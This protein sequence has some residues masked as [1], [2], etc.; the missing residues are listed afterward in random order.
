MHPIAE[1][2]IRKSALP[3]I[4]CPGC[5]HGTVLNAFLHAVD[6]LD[7]FSR[8]ALVS[9]IGCSSWTPVFVNTDVMHTLHGRALAFATGLKIANPKLCVAVFTGDGDGAGIGGNHLIHAARR[10]LDLTVFMLDNT[11]YGMTG[12]QVSPTTPIN[13]KSQT[14]PMG[15]PEPQ[16]DVCALVIAAGA[17]FVAR[18]TTAKPAALIKGIKAAMSHKGFSFLHI[19]SQCPTQAGRYI[20]GMTKPAQYLRMLKDQSVGVKAAARR[21]KEELAGKIITGVLHESHDRPEFFTHG[22][23]RAGEEMTQ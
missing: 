23:R 17:G 8:L 14:T 6:D 20:Y 21:S 16:L 2:Y 9:G 10:N 5:G 1:K 22:R 18:Y 19:L 3:F 15:N 13:G 12:G 7:I 4:F 11:I